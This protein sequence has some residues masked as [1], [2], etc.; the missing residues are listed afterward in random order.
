MQPEV[1][2]VPRVE[3]AALT[4]MIDPAQTALVVIDV[5]E[6][7]VGPTGAMARIGVDMSGVA[8]ALDRIVRLIAAAR[9]AGATIAFARVVSSPDTDSTALKLLN[10]RKGRPPQAIAICREDQTGSAYYRVSPQPGDI[11]APKRLFNTF[12]GT[13]FDAQLRARGVDTLVV[14][15]FTTDCC[16]DSTCRDAFHRD[17]NVFVVSDA[18]DAYAADLHVGALKALQK[19]CALVTDTASVLAAWGARDA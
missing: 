3:P 19:N 4:G 10:A 9:A 6:D 17:Y 2:A 8:P 15:G 7:F 18:T 12:H 1:G 14:V 5:Q 16:V 11:E 13:S